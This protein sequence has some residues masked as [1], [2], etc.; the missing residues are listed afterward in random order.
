MQQAALQKKIP[1]EGRDSSQNSQSVNL[2]PNYHRSIGKSLM[3]SGS[4]LY[5]MQNELEKES[6]N[7][8]RTVKEKF[9]KK[10]VARKQS[11]DIPNSLYSFKDIPVEKVVPKFPIVAESLEAHRKSITDNKYLQG[12]LEDL[13]SYKGGHIRDTSASKFPKL[14]KVIEIKEMPQ[15]DPPINFEKELKQYRRSLLQKEFDKY[16]QGY[17]SISL[18]SEFNKI[19]DHISTIKIALQQIKN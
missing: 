2:S 19:Q 17:H 7:N 16:K 18:Q 9:K 14:S 15:P 12:F 13:Q 8:I 3:T 5:H 1:E 11:I 4:D 6:M 10:A